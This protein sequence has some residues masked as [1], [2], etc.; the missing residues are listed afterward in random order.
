MEDFS[1]V[2]RLVATLLRLHSS[3]L[4]SWV[5]VIVEDGTF[6][7]NKVCK[8]DSLGFGVDIFEPL[9]SPTFASLADDLLKLKK[10]RIDRLYPFPGV[11]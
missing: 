4:S 2:M 10:R 3:E 6:L 1:L 7:A 5:T 8:N 9:F 11:L